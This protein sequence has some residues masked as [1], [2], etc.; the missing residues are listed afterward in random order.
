M[1]NNTATV[2]RPPSL[3]WKILRFPLTRIV[4]GILFVGI[5]VAM[6]QFTISLLKQVFALSSPLPIAFDLLE[7][8]LVVLATSLAYYAYVH[9]IE[10]RP[11]TELARRHAIGELGIGV[12]TGAGVF[13]VVIG[14]LWLLGAYQVTGLNGWSAL[15]VALVADLPSAFLQQL[16]L[17]GILFRITEQAVGRWWALLMT[18]LVF[19]LVHLIGIPHITVLDILSIL[20]AGL[21][22]TTTYLL[23][24]RLWLPIG[25]HT[26]WEVTKDGIFGAGVAGTSGV[27]LQGWIRAH[28]SGPA[29]LTGGASGAEASLVAI[30]AILA[31]GSALLVRAKQQEE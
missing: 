1:A 4:L 31:L 20:L 6:A 13:T 19:G 11:V 27:A 18:V 24:R 5:G 12:L 29:F 16:L 28:L 3:V 25:L 22:F 17:L 26:A 7:I 9:L 2:V 23:T 15:I 30:V 14:I 10:Q 21:L 8:P